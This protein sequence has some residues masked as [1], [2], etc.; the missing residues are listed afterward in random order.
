MV[1]AYFFITIVSNF[2][3]ENHKLF[4]LSF[5][6]GERM[7]DTVLLFLGV[8]KWPEMKKTVVMN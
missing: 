6:A 4:F 1:V 5:L 3:R 2:T 8:G 7:Q